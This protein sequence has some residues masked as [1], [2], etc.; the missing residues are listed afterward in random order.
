M[1]QKTGSTPIH[2]LNLIAMPS[3][4]FRKYPGYNPNEIRDWSQSTGIDPASFDPENIAF[5][6]VASKAECPP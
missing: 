3:Y 1:L 5:G 6:R 4:I 2:D